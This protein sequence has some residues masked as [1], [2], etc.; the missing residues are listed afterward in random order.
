[1]HICSSVSQQVQMINGDQGSDEKRLQKKKRDQ[2][3][4]KVHPKLCLCC[5]TCLELDVRLG[6][7]ESD[8]DVKSAAAKTVKCRTFSFSMANQYANMFFS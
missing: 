5:L 6:L 8:C 4:D 7:S 3:C 2:H 1:M